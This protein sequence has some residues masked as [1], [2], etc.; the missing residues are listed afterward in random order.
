MKC[1]VLS[2]LARLG[3]A[4]EV[5]FPLRLGEVVLFFLIGFSVHSTGVP[6][7][8]GGVPDVVPL[9]CLC[10][11]VS[12]HVS[13]CVSRAVG[14]ASPGETEDTL[15]LILVECVLPLLQHPTFSNLSTVF[16]SASLF[17]CSISSSPFLVLQPPLHHF[18]THPSRRPPFHH[19]FIPMS[20]VRPNSN[21]VLFAQVLD[22]K[23]SFARATLAQNSVP[24]NLGNM[25]SVPARVRAECANED[26]VNVNADAD[27]DAAEV[28]FELTR[29]YG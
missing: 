8:W 12:D 23:E 26:D 22:E 15:E 24:V 3:P 20:I 1:G 28:T 5:V 13:H 6:S 11:C 7:C 19:S 17:A 18:T 29:G 16:I 2:L 21:T 9:L 14:R 10:S 25:N 4:I 27:G